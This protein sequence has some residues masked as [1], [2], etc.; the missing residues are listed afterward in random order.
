[1]SE[2]RK[3]VAQKLSERDCAAQHF[4]AEGLPQHCSQKPVWELVHSAGQ[5]F[6]ICEYH[7]EVFWNTWSSFREAVRDV[8][9][10]AR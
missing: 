4:D 9:P 2:Q 10:L 1:M 5:S 3:Y 6:H 8:W 7:I